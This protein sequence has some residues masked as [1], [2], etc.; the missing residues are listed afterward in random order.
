MSQ[1]TPNYQDYLPTPDRE[2]TTWPVMDFPFE[3]NPIPDVYARTLERHYDV[4]PQ[5][6]VPKNATVASYTNRIIHTDDMTSIAWLKSISGTGVLPVVTGGFTG[7]DGGLSA[8]RL[9][10]DR[11]SGST[12]IISGATLNGN[13]EVTTAPFPG[14]PWQ[15]SQTGG[16]ATGDTVLFHSSTR[17]FKFTLAAGTNKK[18]Q[19]WQDVLVVGHAYSFS[20]YAIT[21]AGAPTI[22]FFENG[23]AVGTLVTPAGTWAQYSGTFTATGITFTGELTCLA[24]GDTINLDDVELTDVTPATS[25]LY[26]SFTSLANPHSS[27][28]GVWAKSNTG[29]SQIVGIYD[30]VNSIYVAQ[31]ITPAWQRFTTLGNRGDTSSTW[32]VGSVGS[33]GGT[34][35]ADILVALPQFD[36]AAVIGPFVSTIA[37]ARTVSV[38]YVDGVQNST[39]PGADIFAF[40]VKETPLKNITNATAQLERTYARIPAPQVYP[41]SKPITRPVM[42]NIFSGSTYAVSFNEGRTSHLFNV[43]KAITSIGGLT[44][45]TI[46]V[47]Q[48]FGGLPGDTITFTDNAGLGVGFAM[49]AAAS[50]VATTL[51]GVYGTTVLKFT[52]ASIGGALVI[53][54]TNGT[55]YIKTIETAATL[56]TMSGG[57]PGTSVTFTA[58]QANN[59]APNQN[60]SIRLINCT[61]H[62]ASATGT[63]VAFWNGNV[64]V[65]RSKVMTI[66]T[67]DSFTV[68]SADVDGKDLVLTHCAFTEDALVCYANSPIVT[69]TVRRTQSFYLPGYSLLASGATM[70]TFAD[71]PLQAPKM[72]AQSWLDA[73]VAGS[74]WV[75]EDAGG[76]QPWMGPILSQEV[77][78]VQMSDALDSVSVLP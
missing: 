41:D 66:P 19:V 26:Q 6:Y 4:N 75:V 39:R 68:L 31:T 63:R 25:L 30:D 33:I 54:W 48:T 59:M 57:P 73:I 70:A 17:S 9:Q 69:C 32:V 12:P 45:G 76:I 5:G 43:R 8:W 74:A 21:S 23:N 37:A 34:Q 77:S 22:R 67:A 64:L 1:P 2:T 65:A 10:M 53:S 51:N 18:A 11:G 42:D 40:L 3:N 62:G 13:F 52:A 44:L 78:E 36:T 47:P 38:P 58:T 27:A 72:D 15:F 46:A 50:S 24:T 61:G 14:V 7:P 49:N 60:P 35:A 16:T 71:I 29:V 20:Y 55:G 56:A 28:S